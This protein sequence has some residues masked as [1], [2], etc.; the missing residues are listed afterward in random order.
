MVVII[1]IIN[2]PYYKKVK[3][4]NNLKFR[5]EVLKEKHEEYNSLKIMISRWQKLP[6]SFSL[7]YLL[8]SWAVLFIFIPNIQYILEML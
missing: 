3:I 6:F 4:I 7:V 8:L 1:I 5:K 2:T